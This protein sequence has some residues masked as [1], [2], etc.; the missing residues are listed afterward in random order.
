[1]D[2]LGSGGV[3]YAV[4]SLIRANT[5]NS[6]P[7]A[8]DRKWANYVSVRVSS[9]DK[10]SARFMADLAVQW[11]DLAMWEQVVKASGSEKKFGVLGLDKFVLAWKKF[12]FDI[13]K[14]T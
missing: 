7:T 11:N 3:K 5:W 14:E 6:Q 4:Q 12:S 9:K 1:L 8:N 10:A 13:V 2:V